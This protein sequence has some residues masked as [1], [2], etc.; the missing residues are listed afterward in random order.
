VGRP[1]RQTPYKRT[2]PDGRVVWVARCFDLT[3]KTRY[4]K[5]RWNGGKATFALKRDAQ[6]AIDEELQ[7]L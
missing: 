6:A 5:P 2:Y 1:P 3:G 7:L 4:A